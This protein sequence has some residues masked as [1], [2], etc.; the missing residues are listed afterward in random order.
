MAGKFDNG[1][2]ILKINAKP[3]FFSPDSKG[4]TVFEGITQRSTTSKSFILTTVIL[5]VPGRGLEP[6]HGA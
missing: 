6:S 4:E 2:S 1:V 3:T 5:F